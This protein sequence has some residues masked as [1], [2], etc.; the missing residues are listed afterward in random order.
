M[1]RRRYTDHD[2]ATTL[3]A[4]TA[5]GRNLSKTSR[6]T[7]IPIT[8]IKRWRDEPPHPHI[9]ELGNE[10]KRDLADELEHLAHAIVGIMPDK[11]DTANF[12]HLA[13]ALGITIDKL[14]LLKGEATEVTEVRGSDAKRELAD[15]LAR[16]ASGRPETPRAPN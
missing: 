8:T 14:R 6:D 12:Q 2:K 9:A 11:M 4:L 16:L 15:R 5:N 1:A 7:G 10:K 3:A 13:V